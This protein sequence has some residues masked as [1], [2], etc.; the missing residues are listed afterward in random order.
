ML[1]NATASSV[2]F[3]RRTVN[4]RA[5]LLPLPHSNSWPSPWRLS[6]SR[7]KKQLQLSLRNVFPQPFHVWSKRCTMS[8]PFDII[9]KLWNAIR[10]IFIYLLVLPIR[11]YRHVI[12]PLFPPRCRY[13]P[14]CS[15]YAIEALRKHGPLKG[16][17]LAIYRILR[18]NPFGGFGYDPVPDSFRFFYYKKEMRGALPPSDDHD[19]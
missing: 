11:L 9:R 16:L 19:S 18:C 1:S 13:T 10:Q 7:R 5:H 3:A 15:Q 6:M 4:R 8:R 14:S 2:Y 17:W 12:S